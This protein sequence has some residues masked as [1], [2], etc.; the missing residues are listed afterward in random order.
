MIFTV[1][2]YIKT[3]FGAKTK[4]RYVVYSDG[5]VH[6]ACIAFGQDWSE[7]RRWECDLP[8]DPG[9]EDGCNPT[10]PPE[11]AKRWSEL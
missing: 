6:A 1:K 5:T 10:L 4:T 9:F 2:S 8:E 3:D 11:V 7:A